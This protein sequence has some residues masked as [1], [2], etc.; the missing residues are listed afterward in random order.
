MMDIRR[1]LLATDLEPHSDRAMERAVQLARRHR[2]IL[3]VLY[4]IRGG[5]DRRALDNLPPH[6]IEAEMV[7][8]LERIP[9][10]AD[11]P[12]VVVA[13]GGTVESV[14]A[15]HASMWN[16]DLIVVGRPDPVEG[17]TLTSTA[18]AIGIS[19]RLPLLAVA[20]KPFTSYASALVP[21]DF[22]DLSL[23]A[24]KAAAALVP[25]GTIRLLHI[26]DAPTSALT[27]DGEAVAW[28][29]AE[30]SFAEDFRALI[31][32]L[33]PGAPEVST[34]IRLGTP[35]DG[36]IREALTVPS[37]DLMVMG[38]AGRGGLGR[39]LFGSVAHEVLGDVPCDVLIVP[40]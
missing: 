20:V 22:S 2:A 4:A 13:T 3:T 27:R 36:I 34:A 9:G 37:P 17:V 11:L 7:R 21:V 1:I 5:K 35:V 32:A 15:R 16:A 8:H 25:D 23:P 6:H 40:E 39:A 30:R 33:P 24:L 31:D 38:S 10:A 28:T 18:E 14:V 29:L 12:L 26:H 19:G